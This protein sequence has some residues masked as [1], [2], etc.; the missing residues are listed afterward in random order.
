[1][2]RT[3]HIFIIPQTPSALCP[4]VVC[5]S[6]LLSDRFSGPV[7]YMPSENY[8]ACQELCPE[9]TPFDNYN[10]GE[11]EAGELEKDVAI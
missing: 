8:S 10:R 7:A 2:T 1:M 4:F 3:T 11:G 9:C 6:P 5:F